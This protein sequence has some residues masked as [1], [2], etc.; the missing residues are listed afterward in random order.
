[1]KEMEKGSAFGKICPE[2]RKNLTDIG[3]MPYNKA[4]ITEKEE[5]LWI[6]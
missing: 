1:M 5:C 3:M 2:K 6:L 4:R